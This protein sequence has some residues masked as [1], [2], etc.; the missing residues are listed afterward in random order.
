MEI[1]SGLI[2]AVN[3]FEVFLDNLLTF[4]MFGF[5]PVSFL[6][7]LVLTIVQIVKTKKH[8]LKPVKAIVFGIITGVLAVIS[9]CEVV[10]LLLLASAVAHM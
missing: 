2:F 3:Y 1:F 6:V 7:F 9:I 10:M 5:F 8:G 4:T